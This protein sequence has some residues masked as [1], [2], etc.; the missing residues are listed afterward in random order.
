M[1]ALGEVEGVNIQSNHGRAN[2][3]MM[4]CNG[5]AGLGKRVFWNVGEP[6]A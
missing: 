6:L 3:E 5:E 1:N 4:L 2:R